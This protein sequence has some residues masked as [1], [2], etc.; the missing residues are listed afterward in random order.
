[1]KKTTD[2]V[3]SV[4]G[5]TALTGEWRYHHISNAGIHQAN[6]GIS[7]S[8]ILFGVTVFLK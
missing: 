2:C 1:M 4:L 6:S 7:S 3:V 8:V 5:R